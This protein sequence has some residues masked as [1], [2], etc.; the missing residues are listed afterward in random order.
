MS[1]DLKRSRDYWIKRVSKMTWQRYNDLEKENKELIKFY[2]QAIDQVERELAKL[3]IKLKSNPTLTNQHDK[4]RLKK[5]KIQ[6]E[7]IVVEL[8]NNIQFFAE[9][10]L[11]KA[12]ENQYR[13]VMLLIGNNDFS[14]PNE[15]L[16]KTMM[17]NPWSGANF[18]ERLWRNKS[19]LEFN[20]NEVLTRGFIQGKTVAQIAEELSRRM[21]KNID[22]CLRL[23]RTE[24]MHYLNE[25]AKKAYQD[26]G[27]EQLM[28]WAAED[29][30]TCSTC[31]GYH[32]EIMSFN[33]IQIFPLHPNCR[34]TY[35]PI[36]E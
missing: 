24:R 26:V 29:E 8:T 7:K 12:I 14:G 35:I 13:D 17:N 33:K 19:L 15:E 1:D 34:C 25:S 20:L 22:V 6:M 28:Y 10:Q 21:S 27:V 11:K 2:N 3:A 9:E 18:G 5:L 36:I 32:E 30:R 4:K 16:I 23:V 31:G